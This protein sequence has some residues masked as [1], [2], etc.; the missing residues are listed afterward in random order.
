MTTIAARDGIVAFDSQ[1]T[2]DYVDSVKKCLKRGNTVIG[3][4]G[5]YIAGYDFAVRYLAGEADEFQMSSH[6]DFE[7]LVADSE[8]LWL[9]DCKGRRA[10]C[11]SAGFTAIGSGGAAAMAAMYMGASAEEAVKIAAKV[12][13]YTGGR[14]RT[15]R[16]RTG[17]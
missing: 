1:A 10:P 12:D 9:V 3:V 17:R 5:D 7:C 14:I 16:Y 2:G 6:D 11:G 4:T 8:G 15:Y 13:P